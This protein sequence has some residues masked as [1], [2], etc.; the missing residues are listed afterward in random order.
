MCAEEFLFD[1]TSV[2]FPIN[3]FNTE[4]LNKLETACNALS[5]KIEIEKGEGYY[6]VYN[7]KNLLFKER[8]YIEEKFYFKDIIR[9][10]SIKDYCNDLYYVRE[11]FYLEKVKYKD[12]KIYSKVIA[13]NNI[14]GLNKKEILVSIEMLDKLN[15]KSSKVEKLINIYVMLFLSNKTIFC[16]EE[17]SFAIFH[18]N[19]YFLKKEK[20]DTITT[21]LFKIYKWIVSEEEYKDSYRVKLDIVRKVIVNKESF[22]LTEEDLLNCRSIFNRIIRNEVKTYF[23]Q[24]DLLKNDFINLDKS[25]NDVRRSLHV[26][27]LTWLSSIGILIFDYIKEYEGNRIY[28]SIFCSQSQ[29]IQIV[30]FMLL[31]AIVVIFCIFIIEM[32]YLEK[33]YDKLKKYYTNKQFFIEDDFDNYIEKPKIQISYVIVFILVII[34]FLIRIIL[35]FI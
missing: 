12:F 15:S 6:E 30:L 18:E 5:I 23:E 27:I 26:K 22:N 21:D 28:Y 34:A 20:L 16:D 13:D 32:N 25:I 9:K 7:P 11:D 29:K 14:D 19:H 35:T 3:D 31:I 17:F 33:E 4:N 10:L 2:K 1:Y 8:E 24:V